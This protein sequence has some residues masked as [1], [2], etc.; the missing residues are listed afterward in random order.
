VKNL[1]ISDVDLFD[2]IEAVLEHRRTGKRFD[3][4]MDFEVTK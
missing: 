3:E 2:F 4:I 1:R